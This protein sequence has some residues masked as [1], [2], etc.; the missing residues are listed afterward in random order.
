VPRLRTLLSAIAA[1]SIAGCS[2]DPLAIEVSPP[3]E[4]SWIAVVLETAEGTAVGSTGILRFVRGAP[5]RGL[6]QRSSP[7]VARVRIAAWSDADIAPI[8]GLPKREIETA[9]VAKAAPED[10]LLPRPTW[11]GSAPVIDGRAAASPDRDPLD[12]TAP[13]LP[14]CPV[15][16]PDG[17]KTFIDVDCDDRFHASNAS[18]SGCTLF[19]GRP[20]ADLGFE[21]AELDGRGRLAL[22]S[23]CSQ[24]VDP[25]PGAT[26]TLRCKDCVA[27]LYVES[28]RAP[29]SVGPAIE[30]LGP[31]PIMRAGY[32]SPRPGYASSLAVLAPSSCSASERIAVVAYD[33][34][35]SGQ[36]GCRDAFGTRIHFFDTATGARTSSVAA[37]ACIFRIAADPASSSSGFFGLISGANA[38]LVRFDCSGRE[39]GRIPLPDPRHE[40]S[41]LAIAGSPPRIVV[42]MNALMPYVPALVLAFDPSSLALTS[43]TG[44]PHPGS[45]YFDRFEV[46]Y[47]MVEA[48]ADTV[49]VGTDPDARLCI[50]SIVGRAPKCNRLASGRR[51]GKAAYYVGAAGSTIV[52]ASADD[53]PVVNTADAATAQWIAAA[54]F[55]EERAYPTAVFGIDGTATEQTALV[56]LSAPS[57]TRIA[58]FDAAR[59][60]FWPGSRAIG[61]PM[62]SEAV[63]DVVRDASGHYWLLLPWSGRIVRVEVTPN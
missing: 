6:H 15:L 36:L 22:G 10:P 4:V 9:R 21:S 25:T 58:L 24:P 5:I 60:R 41:N 57:G 8:L 7:A 61:T 23:A 44:I 40:P 55:F 51:I 29:F 34:H 53:D 49:A 56:A 59:V 33:G 13:Y 20:L 14:A 47:S 35:I 45:E 46:L 11:S 54:A 39:T 38:S 37:P 50:S 2:A 30:V 63:G 26:L 12:L 62:Q 32:A 27:D 28:D 48:S 1:A 19:G 3:P 43:S 42:G 16:I 17:A 52:A 31:Q 18:Q